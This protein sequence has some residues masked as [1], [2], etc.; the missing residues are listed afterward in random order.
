MVSKITED[1]VFEP[2][3][4]IGWIIGNWEYDMVREGNGG[5]V[6]DLNN[7]GTDIQTIWKFF[8]DT[9]KC[10]KVY[11]STNPTNSE[12]RATKMEIQKNYLVKAQNDKTGGTR[13]LL[14]VY[15]SGHGVLDCT[16]HC[17]LNEEDIKE[18]FYPLE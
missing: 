9:I 12:M 16:T 11:T 7:V 13:V 10:D 17:V 1:S 5:N 14:Y 18:R 4:T 8:Q 15:Y 3:V 6:M 2:N